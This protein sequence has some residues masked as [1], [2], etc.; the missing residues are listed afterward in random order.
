MADTAPEVAIAPAPAIADLH[1]ALARA[2]DEA[3]KAKDVAEKLLA[4]VSQALEDSEAEL[5]ALETSSK[6]DKAKLARL[7]KAGAAL[8][9]KVPKAVRAEYEAALKD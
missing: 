4:D 8:A 7:R 9:A 3:Q 2:L 6:A 5:E 1:P